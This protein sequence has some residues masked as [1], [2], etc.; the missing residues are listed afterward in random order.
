MIISEF[1]NSRISAV[2]EILS[3]V[4]SSSSPL[5]QKVYGIYEVKLKL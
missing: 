2:N 4:K 1:T 3:P 5:I